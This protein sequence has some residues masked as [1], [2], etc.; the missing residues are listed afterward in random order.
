MKSADFRPRLC[1]AI[2]NFRH[3]GLLDV[4]E[5]SQSF[6]LLA[7]QPFNTVAFGQLSLLDHI[8]PSLEF[9]FEVLDDAGML[10]G[11]VVQVQGILL[12][13]LGRWSAR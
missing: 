6:D 10:F 8:T 3:R 12:Q 9:R 2:C 11:N 4:A 1:P 13:R 5:R 7:G